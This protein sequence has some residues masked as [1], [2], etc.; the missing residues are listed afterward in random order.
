[1]EAAIYDPHQA[2]DCVWT[3]FGAAALRD[4][5]GSLLMEGLDGAETFFEES[6]AGDRKMKA[7]LSEND[8]NIHCRRRKLFH[9]AAEFRLMCFKLPLFIFSLAECVFVSL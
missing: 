7:L 3:C 6:T 8:F 5:M 4:L 9:S 1:M 2:S